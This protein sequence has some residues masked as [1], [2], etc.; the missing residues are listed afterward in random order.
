[1]AKVYFRGSRADAATLV[2]QVIQ[3][4][5]GRGASHAILAQGVHR[6][7]GMAALSDIHDDFVRKAKGGTG[8]DGV[9]WPPLAPATLAYGRRAPKGKGH[10]PGGKDGLLTRR[11]LKR[12][13]EI[14]GT[15]LA[16]FAASM[17]LGA[18]KARAAK[19]AWA[20]VKAEGGKTKIAEY[21]NIPHEIL[22]DTGVLLNSLS[23]GEVG[24]NS[25]QIFKTILGGVIVGTNVPYAAAHQ[26][27]KRPFLPKGEAPQVWRDRWALTGERAITIALEHAI[28]GRH[29]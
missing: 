18:A 2:R 28:G 8:E 29:D 7:I 6:S 22:R 23:P 14:Y 9:K 11:Q 25:D 13:R 3:S 1:M 16:R 27:G 10:A 17:P 4:L 19:I 26:N 20:T 21:A 12:W 24:S 5:T 15:R